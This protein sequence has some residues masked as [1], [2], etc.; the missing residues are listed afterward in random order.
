MENKFE[1]MPVRKIIRKTRHKAEL[2][3]KWLSVILS[4]L[5]FLGIG[6]IAEGAGGDL[7]FTQ[8]LYSMIDDPETESMVSVVIDLGIGCS[9]VAFFGIIVLLLYAFYQQ[10]AKVMAYSVK[11]TPKNFPEIYAKAAEYTEAL[12]LRKQPDVY[13]EAEN[14]V[15]N[16]FASY[17]LGRRY[18]KI[19]AELV[20]IAYMENRDFDTLYFVMAHEF[21]HIYLHHVTLFYNLFTFVAKLIPLYGPLFSRAQEYSA[22]RVAQALTDNKNAAECMA[23]LSVGRHLYKHMDVYDYLESAGERHNLLERLGRFIVNLNASHPITPFRV[24]AVMDPKRRSGRLI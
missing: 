18:V 17:V 10:Y 8:E 16:A 3:L 12:G 14:G 1:G 7:E 13:I 9:V 11:V 21:G 2:P 15:L 24:K 6:L 5:L 20:D 4:V 22:D 23:L 19:N